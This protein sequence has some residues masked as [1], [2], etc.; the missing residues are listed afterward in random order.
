MPLPCLCFLGEP[1]LQTNKGRGN[2]V[3]HKLHNQSDEY[4]STPGPCEEKLAKSCIVTLFIF[5]F[6]EWGPE[7]VLDENWRGLVPVDLD[8]RVLTI[9]N[10]PAFLSSCLTLCCPNIGS[11]L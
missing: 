5:F 11:P 2:V 10:K 8:V 4:F 9:P 7:L 3:K 6:G 1:T